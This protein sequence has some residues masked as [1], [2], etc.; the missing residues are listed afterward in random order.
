[1]KISYAKILVFFLLT[2]IAYCTNATIITSNVLINQMIFLDDSA[3]LKK[4]AD[5][6]IDEKNHTA[7][8]EIFAQAF[9]F[10]VSRKTF[11][12][13]CLQTLI[14]FAEKGS[15][16]VNI[17]DGD[18]SFI[19]HIIHTNNYILLRSVLQKNQQHSLEFVIKRDDID[20]IIELVEKNE[21]L[22]LLNEIKNY[23]PQ[24]LS[25]YLIVKSN[26]RYKWKILPIQK[27]KNADEHLPDV[28]INCD[29]SV[30]VPGDSVE[31]FVHWV[32]TAKDGS[33]EG[34]I[35]KINLEK[36]F[37]IHENVGYHGDIYYK[38]NDLV[39]KYLDLC[40][41]TPK[42]L[43]TVG[44]W[45]TQHARVTKTPEIVN[46][47]GFFSLIFNYFLPYEGQIQY[48]DKTSGTIELIVKKADDKYAHQYTLDIV[49]SGFWQM[50]YSKRH[51]QIAFQ[52]LA[53]SVMSGEFFNHQHKH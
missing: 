34:G 48:N 51:S 9:K 44:S 22:G 28:V 14:N 16:N 36:D 24:E 53:K 21:N 5:R 11:R 35:V 27:I 4:M 19:N 40:I 2:S 52:Q 20:S 25:K 15:W 38:R 43:K 18:K 47:Q 42:D 3:K 37:Y 26:S 33:Q 23:L 10:A 7:L 8:Q 31:L 1:M 29:K 39:P 50:L 41:R 45:L 32:M 12:F 49:D 46:I 30:G 17:L 13:E 6:I